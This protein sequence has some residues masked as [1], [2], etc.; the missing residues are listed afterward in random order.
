MV[1]IVSHRDL[2]KCK[3]RLVK[4]IT[5]R[6]SKLHLWRE[7]VTP[8]GGAP[9]WREGVTPLRG[10]LLDVLHLIS[11]KNNSCTVQAMSFDEFVV[12]VFPKN[13]FLAA[14]F[15]ELASVVLLKADHSS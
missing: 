4:V 8:L 6:E 10:A 14:I 15:P 1:I 3:R 7:G 2:K 12:D 9:A 13:T 5:W 11:D